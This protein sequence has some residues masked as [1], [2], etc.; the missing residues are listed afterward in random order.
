VGKSLPSISSQAEVRSPLDA[1]SC[2]TSG[3][4]TTEFLPTSRTFEEDLYR[5][6]VY[7][8]SLARGPRTFSLA[9]S[10]QRTQS[11]SMLSGLSLSNVSN[12]AIQRLP[13]YAADLKYIEQYSFEKRQS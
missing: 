1:P 4:Q 9:T 7:R 11:W 8:R 12:I 13:I 5:S 2:S 3:H 6:W 10:A